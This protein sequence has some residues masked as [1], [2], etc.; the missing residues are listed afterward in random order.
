MYTQCPECFTVFK[1]DA[2][3]LVPAC[4]CVRCN[5]CDTVFNAL[6]T[7]AEQLPPEPFTRLDVHSL[8]QEPPRLDIAVFRPRPAATAPLPESEPANLNVIVDEQEPVAA[9]ESEDFSTLTFTPRFARKHRGRRRLGWA[10]ASIFL[11]LGLSAQLAWAKREELISDPQVGPLLQRACATL[12]CELPLVHDT[13]QLRLLARDVQAHPSV[14]GALLISASV[15]N[16]AHFAQPFP[17]VTI[18]LADVDGKRLAM[19]RFRP[20]E[21][22]ADT[23]VRERGLAPGTNA[24]MVFEV[25]DP[26]QHAVAFEFA[27]E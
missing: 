1:L 13:R 5:H 11:L 17:V 25:Q 22:V 12:H 15:R 18:T 27:F 6:G 16:D 7:L 20:A 4:G 19:R 10:F 24:A 9:G 26:G 23:A 14:T 2:A 3:M 21:Y 8:D